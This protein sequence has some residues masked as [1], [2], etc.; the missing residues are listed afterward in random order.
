M[1]VARLA[2]CAIT[3]APFLAA[4][5]N[6]PSKPIRVIG[7]TAAGSTSDVIAR[8]LGDRMSQAL[9][10][11]WVVEN[12]LG[13][14]GIIGTEM[15]ARAPA[16]GH[17]LLLASST[18]IALPAMSSKLTFDITKDL[19]PVIWICSSPNVLI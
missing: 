19:V 4:A 12:R 1:I 13:A 5:Q 17:T 9:G 15:V 11:P 8:T 7:V 6:F 18:T 3:A 10:Q 2:A 16:D 14:S